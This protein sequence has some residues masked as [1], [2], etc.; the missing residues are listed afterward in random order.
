[1][2]I[3]I[4]EDNPTDRE[5]L[6]EALEEHFQAQA[7]FREASNLLDADSYLKRG[8]VDCVILDLG[9]PDSAGLDT[10]TRIYMAYPQIPI[11]VMS[12]TA[13]LK[14]ATE[15]IKAGAED[16]ILKDYTN[17]VALFRRVMF[18]IER[19]SR[20]RRRLMTDPPPTD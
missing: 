5:L 1:M 10:F 13:N 4:V 6:I 12:N 9:L 19:C 20:N 18:A 3:L 8:S 7:R 17:T 14:L 2:N 11:V 15:M 16:Y